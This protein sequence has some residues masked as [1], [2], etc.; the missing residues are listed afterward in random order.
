MGRHNNRVILLTC[1]AAL[2]LILLSTGQYG[3]TSQ[4]VGYIREGYHVF[5]K[6]ISAPFVFVADIWSTY[7][8]LVNTSRENRELRLRN[9]RLKVRSMIL[10]ELKSENR[11]LRAM[12]D[13][14]E[15]HRELS[16]IPANLLSQDITLIF[17]TAIIDR[18]SKSGFHV[19]MPILSPDGVV[20]KVIAVSPH[21]SQILLITDPNSAIPAHIESTRV[22]GIIKG[23]GG[24]LLTLEYVR[25]AED[26]KIGDSI[27]TSG[28]LNVFPS[29]LKIGTVVEV[30]RDVNQMFADIIVKPYVEMDK[31]EGIFGIAQDMEASD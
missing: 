4:G 18:G 25:K 10:D 22:K 23:R 24:N 15:A 6:I 2:I 20:G 13:F 27:V 5:D 3:A 26:V 17:K 8:G 7:I 31:I 12:L 14:K 11:R 19:D 9:D 30:R 16:L 29:G 21:T 1:S 28:L